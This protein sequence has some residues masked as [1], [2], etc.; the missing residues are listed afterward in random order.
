LYGRGKTKRPTKN[1]VTA[2]HATHRDLNHEGALARLSRVPDA[3][4]GPNQSTH[5]ADHTAN[6]SADHARI[7]HVTPCVG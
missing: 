2:S 7:H 4:I 5:H 1:S 3:E 6:N